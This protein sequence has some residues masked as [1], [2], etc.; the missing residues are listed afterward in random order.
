MNHPQTEVRK[1]IVHVDSF[2][3]H[4]HKHPPYKNDKALLMHDIL[5]YNVIKLLVA[6]G[7]NSTR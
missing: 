3:K 4:T 7:R 2:I 6:P 1:T 5:V